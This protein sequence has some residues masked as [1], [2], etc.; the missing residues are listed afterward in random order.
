MGNK[1][2]KVVA[3]G[4]AAIVVIDVDDNDDDGVPSICMMLY[5]T[6]NKKTAPS[7]CSQEAYWLKFNTRAATW[8][9]GL[10]AVTL[11]KLSRF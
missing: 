5:R 1:Q 6:T 2:N 8:Q 9:H 11:Q 3:A 7:S 10:S 4:S